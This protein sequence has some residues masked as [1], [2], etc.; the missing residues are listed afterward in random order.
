MSPLEKRRADS[1]SKAETLNIAQRYLL[2]LL[3]FLCAVNSVWAVDPSRHISQYEHTAWR[4][5]D[6]VF[7]GAPNT[8]T[9][10]AD[11]Y[12]WIGT[13][14]G[15]VRFDGVRFVPW[16]PPDG[17]HLPSS[18]V[19][20]LLGTRDGSLW[21]GMEGGLSHWDKRNLTNYP[22]SKRRINTIIED[23]SGT[24]WFAR[25]PE[26]DAAGGLCQAIGTDMRCYGGED[27]IPS[28]SGIGTLVEDTLGNLWMGG[29]AEVVRWKSGTFSRFSLRGLKSNRGMDGVTSLVANSDGSLWVGIALAGRG[30]GLQQLAQGAWKPFV[31][32]GLDGST[33][34]VQALFL[35]HENALWIGTYKQ[36]IYRIHG[37]GVDHFY[38]AD[39]LSSDSVYQFYEDHE[40]NLWVATPK[41]IDCFRDV[42]VAT[43]STREGLAT[44]EVD[45]VFATQDGTVWIGGVDAFDAIH[46]DGVSSSVQTGKGLP[47][48][49]V[50]SLLE[51]HAGRFWV[52]V[53]NRM[54]I[55]KNG[56]F[57]R[58]DR[59]DG[60]PIGVVSGMTEDVD[61]NIWVEAYGP[62]RTLLRIKDLKVQEE[63]LL[64]QMPAARK[65][66]ADPKGGIWLGLMNGDLARYWHGK[67]E[68][69]SFKQGEDSRVNQLV[70]NSD[71]SVLGA[72]ALGLVGWREGKQQTLTVRNGLPCDAVNAFSEDS[73]R[74]LWLYTQCGLVEIAGTEMQRWWG[75]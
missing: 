52:G 37:R 36:G 12:L 14:A 28:S 66:A 38:T 42:R 50:T 57:R 65:V 74:A 49:Q 23:R 54:S 3:L 43:F 69:F 9:Q 59:P 63:F 27:G 60:S 53:D 73:H 64:P 33:L 39:G 13:Q 31:V 67:T 19:T 17:Q 7:S 70:V 75:R 46:Q 34:G 32:P 68:I 29:P 6:G 62:P 4:G 2:C 71:G 47:G 35:D 72:T 26:I 24:V 30:L 40:G 51:D 48:H 1:V 16:T 21:I 25:I 61:N 5:Q 41:G 20:S 8:I 22:S 45:S 44:P 18:N 55:Y 56:K 11:G 15:L 10:T 58:I